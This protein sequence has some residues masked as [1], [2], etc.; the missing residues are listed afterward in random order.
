VAFSAKETILDYCG[1]IVSRRE[2]PNRRSLLLAG[3][4]ALAWSPVQAQ[5][6]NVLTIPGETR[7]LCRATSAGE[8]RLGLGS[9]LF[10]DPARN[11]Y[12]GLADR[13]P[14][15]GAMSFVSRI[16]QFRLNV[17]PATG[18]IS[19]FQL[20]KTILLKTS[21]GTAT[22][23]GLR[24]SLL[25]GDP[26]TLGLSLDPEG[27]TVGPGGHF[28]VADE[29]GPSLYEFAPVDIGAQTEARFVRS[30]VIPPNVVP[31]DEN[32]V[33]DYEA[34]RKTQP[35]LANGRQSGRGFEGLAITPDG[36]TLLAALQDPLCN[37]GAKNDGC[38]GLN[39][40]LVMFDVASGS[41]KAQFAYQL[42]DIAQINRRIPA[43]A[44]FA[45]A[46]QGRNVG[47]GG[48]AAIDEH[49]F[50]VLERDGRGMDSDNPAKADAVLNAVGSKRVYQIDL[51]GA[52]DISQVSL[53]GS[54]QLPDGIVPVQ[55]T[56]LL[57][58]QL[59]LQQSGC[60]IPAKMEGLAIGPRLEEGQFSLLISTDNDFSARQLVD[61]NGQKPPTLSDIYRDGTVG[62]F[63]GAPLGRQLL[64]I[65]LIALR[66][67]I[68]NPVDPGFQRAKR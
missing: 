44:H 67:A 20:Q 5:L 17:D 13:G 11:V 28:Y 58:V 8:N 3:M 2:L 39:L 10:F 63:G 6:A 33:I 60:E 34:D 42:E 48:I 51:R 41:S 49:R 50:L 30:F 65:Q 62:P 9:D 4:F 54:I 57:D 40:R 47:I 64:P 55:K 15:S 66:T 61:P 27:L 16:Q 46:Q 14:S 31:R 43:H 7:D 36:K 68:P 45:A 19:N 18:A 37:E 38:R 59:A 32:G 24:P 29:L 52:S 22:F 53:A 21:D 56:L 26:H 1:F 25:H 12:Y 23:D 35:P